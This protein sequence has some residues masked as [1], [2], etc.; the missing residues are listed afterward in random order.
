M[1]NDDD[2][3]DF[4]ALVGTE[5]DFYGVNDTSFKLDDTAYEVIEGEVFVEVMIDEHPHR[6][7]PLPVARVVVEECDDTMLGYQLTDLH[8]GHCWLRFGMDFGEPFSMP[9]NFVFEYTA[10]AMPCNE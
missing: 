8:D 6:F 4:D 9:A 1:D 7:P 3:F 2:V 5:A 10:K